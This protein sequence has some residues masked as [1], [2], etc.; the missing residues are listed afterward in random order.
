MHSITGRPKCS[1]VLGLHLVSHLP[2]VRVRKKVLIFVV[3]GTALSGPLRSFKPSVFVRV[4]RASH[5]QC[6]ATM[7]LQQGVQGDMIS[8]WVEADGMLGVAGL[9]RPLENLGLLGADP[10][11]VT[12]LN[13][14]CT[15]V[16][17]FCGWSLAKS[18]YVRVL[19]AKRLPW[20]LAK[21]LLH[22]LSHPTV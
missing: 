19:G 12:F 11:P 22:L 4:R 16:L 6:P 7:A 1:H 9:S 2:S 21:G 15:Q 3:W 10:Q 20:K 14:D 8:T 13:Q 17:N 5:L 18:L